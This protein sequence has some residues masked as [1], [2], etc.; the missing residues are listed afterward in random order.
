MSSDPRYFRHRGFKA[1]ISIYNHF[2]IQAPSHLGELT[3]DMGQKFVSLL[4][5]Y[6]FVFEQKYSLDEAVSEVIKLLEEYE[7]KRKTI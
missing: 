5:P 6:A 7:K 2:G 4:D 3:E 1:I